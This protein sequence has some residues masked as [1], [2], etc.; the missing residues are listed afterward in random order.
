[1]PD[2]TDLATDPA[3]EGG[4]HGGDP[5][6]PCLGKC[7]VA[8]EVR[9]LSKD[10][11]SMRAEV[12]DLR[13]AVLSTLERMIAA[14][15]AK[16]RAGAR[17]RESCVDVLKKAIEKPLLPI[18]LL[19]LLAAVAG[20]SASEVPWRDIIPAITIGAPAPPAPGTVTESYSS[21]SSSTTTP[22]E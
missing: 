9:T 16:V 11:G 13:E 4:N 1:M 15:D 20:V 6:L 12:R 5:V 22:P 18:V 7:V 21:T 19:V 10:L 14:E 3:A 8:G 17:F 2:T